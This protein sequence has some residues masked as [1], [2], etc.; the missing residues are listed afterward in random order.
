MS[1]T[2]DRQLAIEIFKTLNDLNPSYMK[3]I[4]I[5]K[6]R[7]ENSRNPN[8]L[9]TY[10]ENAVTYGENSLKALGPKIWNS[11][12]E[13]FKEKRSINSFK[14]LINTWNG[15]KCKCAMCSFHIN[16]E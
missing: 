13:Y 6:N 5:R 10:M 9:V 4:F 1:I 14:K 3:N 2:R 11:L 8:N 7:R 16:E 12:P 15:I